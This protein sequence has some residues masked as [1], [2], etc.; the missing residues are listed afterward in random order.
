ML[1]FNPISTTEPFK[2]R[3]TPGNSE[4]NFFTKS[5]RFDTASATEYEP[6]PHLSRRDT[7]SFGCGVSTQFV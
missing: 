4:Q 6:M 1:P 2:R 5:M 7:N 3:T